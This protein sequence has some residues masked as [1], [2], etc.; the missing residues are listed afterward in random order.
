M[1]KLGE[2]WRCVSV[3]DA[4][5]VALLI[6][7]VR[8]GMAPGRCVEEHKVPRLH[9]SARGALRCTS[10]AMTEVGYHAVGLAE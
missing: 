9:A 4:V 6:R 5:S 7:G 2:W 3:S 10:L 1:S 8:P